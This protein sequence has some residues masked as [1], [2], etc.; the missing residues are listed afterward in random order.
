M[1]DGVCTHVTSSAASRDSA[2]NKR[3]IHTNSGL[4]IKTCELLLN[5]IYGVQEK[6]NN[7]VMG[8]QSPLLY[9]L[10]WHYVTAYH[11]LYCFL[12]FEVEWKVL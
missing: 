8:F 9:I 10:G 6:C 5:R 4:R 11:L 1:L 3:L 12:D 7:M 2:V